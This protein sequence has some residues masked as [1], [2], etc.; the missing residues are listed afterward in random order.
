MRWLRWWL[1]AR[2]PSLDAASVAVAC[3]AA[4]GG[5]EHHVALKALQE[6][7]GAPRRD[8]R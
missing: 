2:E 6:A 7:L 1:E 3:L 4:L 8:V 5:S